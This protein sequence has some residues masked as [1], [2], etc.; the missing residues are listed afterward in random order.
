MVAGNKGRHANA[1]LA[2]DWTANPR[3]Y[4]V[5]EHPARTPERRIKIIGIGAGLTGIRLAEQIQT[6]HHDLVDLVI[7]EQADQAGGC[8]HWNRYPGVACDVP[9]SNYQYIKEPKTDWTSFYVSGAEIRQYYQ[10]HAKKHDLNKYI[11]YNHKVVGA[12]WCDETGEWTVTTRDQSGKEMLDT[13]NVLISMRGSLDHPKWPELK[14]LLLY[15]G[16]LVHSARYPEGLDL[17]GKRVAVLGSGSSGLQIVPSILD[18]VGHLYHWIRSPT[19]IVPSVGAM[20]AG[21]GGTNFEYTEEK[22]AQFAQDPRHYLLYRKAMESE[23]NK[24]FRF[25]ISG[26]EESKAARANCEE[27]MRQKLVT[28]PHIANKIIPTGFDVGCR[29]PTPAPGYLEALSNPKVT[30]FTDELREMTEKGFIDAEGVEHEVDV[31]I[32]AT[33]FDT[34][35]KPHFPIISRG[36]NL[37]DR[38]AVEPDSYI[39]YAV[40]NYP[41]F[42]IAAGP[43]GAT[44]HGSAVPITEIMIDTFL[45]TVRKLGEEHITSME[46]TEEATRDYMEHAALYLQRT[47]WTG[48]C[49]SWFKKGLNGIPHQY[50]GSR[51]HF[52]EEALAFRPEDWKYIYASGNRFRFWGNGFAQREFDG[53]DNTWYYGLLDGKDEMPDYTEIFAEYARKDW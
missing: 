36:E 24:R 33:G 12:R 3:G 13:C 35:W 52:M 26:S 44:G 17:K 42:L 28:V 8:W 53:R 4:S 23:L 47:V 31:F 6:Y 2:E 41:N 40:P 39:S 48:K 34:T 10:N 18:N 25:V 49:S 46:P 21:P 43:F 22:K 20:F 5:D 45:K 27:T 38:W 50:P 19:W 51:V 30:V 14:G 7:Y 16:V 1:V 15:K 29:R 11:I 37:Q 9:G 32:C